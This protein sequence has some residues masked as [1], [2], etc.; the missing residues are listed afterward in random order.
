MLGVRRISI[1]DSWCGLVIEGHVGQWGVGSGRKKGQC[2]RVG[3]G[4]QTDPGSREMYL[5]GLP[6]VGSSTK[7]A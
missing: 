1:V 3:D 7:G 2:D 6:Q 5:I 4:R